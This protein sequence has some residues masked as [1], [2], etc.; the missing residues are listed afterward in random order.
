MRAFLEILISHIELNV[1]KEVVVA[2]RF[3]EVYHLFK[4]PNL[5]L[6][7]FIVVGHQCMFLDLVVELWTELLK[8]LK[9]LDV[10]R[11]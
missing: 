11:W 7:E 9:T 8:L 5:E 1:K 10:K 2:N 3:F 4:N 6:D